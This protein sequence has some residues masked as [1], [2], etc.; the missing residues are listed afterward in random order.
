[1]MTRQVICGLLAMVSLFIG[2]ASESTA[3]VRVPDIYEQVWARAATAAGDRAFIEHPLYILARWEGRTRATVRGDFS[4]HPAL[5]PGVEFVS[6]QDG[7]LEVWATRERLAE[8]AADSRTTALHPPFHFTPLEVSEARAGMAVGGYEVAGVGGQGVRVAII[9]VDFTDHEFLLGTELPSTVYYKSFIDPR[10]GVPATAHGTA[11]AEIVHDITPKADLYLLAIYE[12][13]DLTEAVEWCIENNIGVVNMSLG[14]IS[15]PRDGTSFQSQLVNRAAAAG[16]IWANAIGNEGD[17]HWGGTAV[18]ADFDGYL[19]FAPGKEVIGFD[20]GGSSD[21]YFAYMNWDSWPS[22]AGLSFDLE[23]YQDSLR[24]VLLT[25]SN[26]QPDLNKAFRQLLYAN[27]QIGPYYLAIKHQFGTIPASLRIDLVNDPLIISGSMSPSTSSYSLTI[28]SDASGAIAV[29]A[30]NY[31]ITIPGSNPARF[32]SSQGPTW[33]GHMKPEIAA[34]DGV[35]TAMYGLRGFPGTSAASPHIA[36]AAALLSSATV[37]GGLFTYVWSPEDFLR[38]LAVR[39]I[40]FGTVGPDNVYGW[41]GV[42]LPPA[43]TSPDSFAVAS[44]YPNPSNAGFNVSFAARAGLSYAVRVYDVLGRLVW[45]T[46]RM[47]VGAKEAVVHWDGRDMDGDEVG[48][49]VYFYR[50]DTDYTTMKGKA[51]LL[52]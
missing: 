22:T 32:Y 2:V 48:S 20:Y 17:V 15:G 38:L 52:K 1:M 8:L 23:L 51:V 34:G 30:Y 4:D 13:T 25:H 28:P 40:D 9:D 46:E 16:I 26:G 14:W 47:H 24:A 7:S 19:E 39:S 3:T 5:P 45:E 18:D 43:T 50:V 6:Q 49:G 35:T 12:S 31:N 29:A 21:L 33:D 27:P 41:G 42:V 11:V 10:L 37:S 44:V 36:G